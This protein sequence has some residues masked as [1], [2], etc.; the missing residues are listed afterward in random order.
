MRSIWLRH[1]LETMAK[2]LKALEAKS[3][4]EGLVLAESQLAALER[5]KLDKEWHGLL[6]RPSRVSDSF[7]EPRQ[8][9]PRLA[10]RAGQ[11]PLPLQGM[12]T[13]WQPLRRPCGECPSG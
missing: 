7:R 6:L 11:P 5:A 3:A 10:L 9:L 4:Q 13:S 2:R 12:N 8:P 1:D